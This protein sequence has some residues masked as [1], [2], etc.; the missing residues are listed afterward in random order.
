MEMCS[1]SGFTWDDE[2]LIKKMNN[3]LIHRGPDDSG[4][5]IDKHISLGHNRLSIIDLSKAGHQPM[6]NNKGTL[7]IIYNGEVYNYKEL[8]EKLEKF[9][10]KFRST[11]DTEVILYAYEHYGSQCLDFFN[12][13]FAIAIWDTVKKEL[14]LARDR[15][16]IK[17]LYYMYDGKKLIFSSELKAILLH[18][19]KK[20]IDLQCLNSF[21]KYRF[22]PS[23]KTM[24]AGIN[25]L[26]PG[27]YAIYKNGSFSVKKYWDLSWE[28]SDKSE[29]YQIAM[30][31]KLLHS[32]IELR[33]NSDVPLG[34]FLSGGIDSSLV[35][36]INSKLRKDKVETFTVGFG[37]E[38][39]EFKYAHKVAEYLSTNHHELILDYKN[40]T[41]KLPDLIWQMDE[42]HSE[43][44]IVP[45][46]F[47]TEFARKRVT[48]VNTGEGAD[49]LFSGYVTYYVGSNMFK[50]IP[51]YF[52]RRLYMWYYSPFKKKDRVKLLKD[53]I[54][55]DD[56]LNNYLLNKNEL[57]YYPK[58][59][60][61]RMLFFDIKHE[62]P[63]WELNRADKMT[64]A[65]SMEA[66]VPFLDHRIVELSTGMK[67]KQK[68]PNLNG[69]YL[70]KK[71]A[72]RY[73]PR[74]IVLRKKQ[75]FFVPMHTWIKDNLEDAAEAILF[76]NKKKFFDYNYIN[77]L[78][79]KH[80]STKKPK[81]FQLYSFQI[82][83]LL[84]FDM[85]YEMYINNKTSKELIRIL[86]I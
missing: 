41:R 84:F 50:P 7:W 82:L 11:S 68:L 78:I 61:N 20:S 46:Y 42:P 39:D 56:T 38:S 76:N 47:L 45:L 37:H 48:V 51:D 10:Y 49:E 73:L 28:I 12:G 35:V 67:V 5:Y 17:P 63:N 60:L 33:L 77:R 23:N 29:N 25:K 18:D 69:K 44:T 32:S 43:I 62:L 64:M 24:L 80:R 14:F 75:G 86:R 4:I 1:I 34:A 9:G 52:R 70:L 3:I 66:R 40:I 36:A 72:L 27:H 65:H 55:E 57:S 79:H 53:S 58:N 83:I 59:L 6:T 21:L 54:T 16:G 74:E 31:E 81:P 2:L 22:I 13:M 15:I 19:L 26:L 8:R 30:L 71:L 85:W